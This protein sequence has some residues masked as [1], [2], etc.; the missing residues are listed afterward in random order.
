MRRFPLAVALL[1]LCAIAACRTAPP[2]SAAPAVE[3]PVEGDPPRSW[4][5]WQEA[6]Q[7]GID[8]RA[9][10]NE[11]GWYLEID[12]EKRMRLLYDYGEKHADTPVPPPIVVNGQTVYDAKTDAH[13][14]HVTI[15]T[16]TCSDG[17]SDEVYPLA[18]EVVIDGTALKGCG[19]RLR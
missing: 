6:T 16:R 5:P 7:R 9:V 12:N 17:M 8:F 3:A 2:P 19:R 15:E 10:G 18:V 14:L 13:T 1:T 4:D 11:P